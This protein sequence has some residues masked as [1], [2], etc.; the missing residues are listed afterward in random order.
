MVWL[1]AG[2]ST[3]LRDNLQETQAEDIVALLQQE[4]VAATKQRA[5]D[6]TWSVVLKDGEQSNAE[7]ILHLY[8][9]PRQQHQSLTDIFPGTGLLPSDLEEHARYQYA[10]GQELASTIERIDGVLSAN[11]QVALPP[12][13]PKQV[14]PPKATASAFV[15]YRSDQRVDLMK[16]QIR[17]LIARGITGVTA[18]DVSVFTL[19]VYPPPRSQSA[20]VVSGWFGVRYVAADSLWVTVWFVLPWLIVAALAVA[21]VRLRGGLPAGWHQRVIKQINRQWK[22]GRPRDAFGSGSRPPGPRSGDVG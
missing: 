20:R 13:D 7:Q 19:P 9:M 8:D 6:G 11:V 4:G 18:D 22:R 1:L 14:D 2:C 12:K 16:S 15:R 10:L 5:N 21:V 17:T 3:S